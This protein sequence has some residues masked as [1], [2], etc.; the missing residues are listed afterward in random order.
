MSGQLL[1]AASALV[2]LLHIMLSSS[3]LCPDRREGGNKRCFC[4]SVRPSVRRA[5]SE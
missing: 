3:L 5:H 1:W 2:A 4:L